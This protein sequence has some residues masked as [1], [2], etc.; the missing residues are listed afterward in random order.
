M[1]CA[2]D[3]SQ[4]QICGVVSGERS[5]SAK[6]EEKAIA[7]PVREHIHLIGPKSHANPDVVAAAYQV[8]GIGD[9][10]DVGSALKWREAPVSE[11]PVP[12]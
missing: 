11:R 6:H 3:L 7:K 2:P 4:Q 1:N 5:S 12:G 8:E 10:K 9:G